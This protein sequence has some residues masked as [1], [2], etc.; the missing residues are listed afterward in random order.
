MM[1][2]KVLHRLIESTDGK[3]RELSLNEIRRVNRI[4]PYVSGRYDSVEQIFHFRNLDSTV[5]MYAWTH[6]EG[7][8]LIERLY[9]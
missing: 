8:I 5:I 9:N 7:G 2:D 3:S 4:E 1:M 6:M